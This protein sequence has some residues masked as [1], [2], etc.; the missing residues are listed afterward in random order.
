ML[1]DWFSR[2]TI[3]VADDERQIVKLVEINLKKVGYDVVCAYEG[4]EALEKAI[5]E[6][7]DV[8]VLDT[9][10]PR[11]NGFD[12]VRRLHS[13]PEVQD[14]PVIMLVPEDQEG[15]FHRERPS[16]HH[17]LVKPFRPNDLVRMVDGICHPPMPPPGGPRLRPA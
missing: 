14:I 1:R 6:C 17:W 3:L 12:V 9:D 16:V 4:V 8:I 13:I 10:M 5:A 15:P 7:P 2:R 11:M